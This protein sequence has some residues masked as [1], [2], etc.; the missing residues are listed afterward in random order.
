MLGEIRG[1]I[2][3][4][5]EKLH[6]LVVAQ[7]KQGTIIWIVGSLIVLIT[8]VVTAFVVAWIMK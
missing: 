1:D 2:K 5:Y 6:D 3:D 8:P 4:I 7:T